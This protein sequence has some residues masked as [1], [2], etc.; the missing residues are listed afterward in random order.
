MSVYSLVDEK[1]FTAMPDIDR[2]IREKECVALTTLANSTRWKLEKTG[3]FPKRI[4]IGERAAGYR[5]SEIQAWIRGDWH[6][7]WKPEKTKQQ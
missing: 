5:L 6:P 4:K 3:K 7:G 1:D 2:V